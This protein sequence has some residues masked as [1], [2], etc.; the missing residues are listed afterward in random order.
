MLS[1]SCSEGVSGMKRISLQSRKL[2][3]AL[4]DHDGLNQEKLFLTSWALTHRTLLNRSCKLRSGRCRTFNNCRPSLLIDG[5][6]DVGATSNDGGRILQQDLQHE[7][8]FS[9]SLR[10]STYAGD[11][12]IE[13]ALM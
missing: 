13:I 6:A 12:D 1:I 3:L 4:Y 10:L 2:N 8:P 5:D 11:R 9:S 7:Y